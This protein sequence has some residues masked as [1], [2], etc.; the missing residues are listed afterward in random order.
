VL[1]KAA[2]A[3]SSTAALLEQLECSELGLSADEVTQRR[4]Q[5]GVN[6]LTRE[7]TTAVR[8]LIRQFQSALIYFLVVAAVLAFA[9][10][11]P[12]DG[13]IITSILVINAALG[14]LQEYRSERAVEKLALL[15]S[16]KVLVKRDRSSVFVEVSDLVPGDIV[17]LKEGDVVPADIRLLVADGVQVDESQLTGESVPVPKRVRV[18]R[19]ADAATDADTS[20]LFTGSTVDKGTL[21][22]VVYA[23][24]NQTELGKIASL[25]TSIRKV[26]QYQ[27][28]LRAF[29]TLLIKVVGGSLVVTLAIKIILEGGTNRIPELLVFVIAL[30]VA[31]VPEALPVIAT[32]TLSRGALTLAREKVIVKRLSSLEDLGNVTLLC[33]DKTGTLTE[34]RLTI[35]SLV[36]VDARL[37]Q[38]LAYAAIDRQGTGTQ[39]SFDAAFD[40]YVA[41]DIKR[42]AH[43][44]VVA[45][46]V[47]FDPADRRRRVVLAN[48]STGVRS[49][50]VIGSAETLLE[51][52]DCPAKRQYLDQI[53]T[54]GEQGMR[55]LALAY[56]QLTPNEPGDITSLEKDLTFLGFVTMS[57]PLRAGIRE[58]IAAARQLGVAIKVL[59]GDSTEVAA[60]VARE[61]GL[62]AQ[63]GKVFSGVELSELAAA[64]FNRVVTEINV[65]ARVS[66]EQKYAIIAALKTHDVVGYQGDGINDAPSLKLA[67]VGIAVDSATEVAKANA[68]IVLLEKDL[69][70]IVN[71]IRYGRI[72]F[73]N[74]NKY[75]KYTMVGNF[76]NFFAL[77]VLY[78]LATDL[79]LLPKQILLVSLLTDLP[80]VAISSDTVAS[81]DLGQPN[82]YDP[83]A[84]LSISLVLGS[85][86]ALVELAFFLTL[87]G[88]SASVSEANLYLFLS[89]TQLIVILS[90]RNRDHF[91]KTVRPSRPLLGAMALTAVITLAVPFTPPVARFFSFDAPSWVDVGLVLVAAAGY[92]LVLDTLKVWYYR[93]NSRRGLHTGAGHWPPWRRGHT[94][95]STGAPR[96]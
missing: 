67:D 17:V 63:G 88:K 23:I 13:V 3:A 40:G 12:S 9:T 21:T 82:R 80:L 65:F 14:F 8:V 28:S 41:Q 53:A 49:V 39:T 2:V 66:P 91:W 1:D 73:A 15:I 56:R 16:D 62:V 33:T 19:Q 78:L 11:D 38:T 43:S 42:E 76:G 26:T 20:L 52:T 54:E 75:I 59:T 70:V 4:T 35:Q 86:T 45:G 74:I 30:A 34:G 55:H 10:N 31:V 83:R 22:G 50:V 37:L 57:D 77:A 27:T 64:D 93:W 60:Y 25:S 61:V 48:S 5:Y 18:D 71:A 85:L 32:L 44:Y 96:P 29:S 69:R 81:A 89:V 72:T 7:R 90:I 94:Q 58:T 47:P 68:D 51:I 79:P 92:V 6:A 84:L 36:S 87:R 95:A 24:A 46:E